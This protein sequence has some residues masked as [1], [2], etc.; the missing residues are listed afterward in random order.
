MLRITVDSLGDPGT[1]DLTDKDDPQYYIA[2]ASHEVSMN[3][4][5][6]ETAGFD[7]IQNEDADFDALEEAYDTFVGNVAT[8]FDTAVA[9]SMDGDPISGVPAI[10]DITAILPWLGPEGWMVFLVKIAIDLTLRWIRKKLDS[11][12]DTKE[13]TAVLRQALIGEIDSTEYPLLELLANIPLTVILDKHGDF[14]DLL[15]SGRP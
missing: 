2:R 6:L 15:Y 11:N 9:E 13:I 10:P 12:T 5:N 14:N 7:F 8:W 4:Y 1:F 3:F